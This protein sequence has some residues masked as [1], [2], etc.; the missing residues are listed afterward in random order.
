MDMIQKDIKVAALTF[1]ADDFQL[2]NILGNRIMSDAV[3]HANINLA[4]TGFFLK[5]VALCYLNLKPQLGDTEFL[6]AK[7]IGEKYIASLSE[8]DVKVDE[9]QAWS[10]YHQ[11]NIDVRKYPNTGIN[12]Q[13]ADVYGDDPQVTHKV[14]GW[15]VDFL[16]TNKTILLD[17]RNNF[18]KG[19]LNDLQ[20][21]GL[22]FGYDVADT[23]VY[24]CLLALDRYYDY[25]RL[26]HSTQTDDIDKDAIKA[27]I[28]PYIDRIRTLSTSQSVNVVSQVN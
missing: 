17:N 23:V 5:N 6:E 26:R 8:V 4:V 24:S 18:I 13:I 25:F 7:L 3:F 19:V 1:K 2:M 14:R 16:Y 20:R 28:F 12:K 10:D 22:T 27:Q 21:V 11:F 9:V 15:L